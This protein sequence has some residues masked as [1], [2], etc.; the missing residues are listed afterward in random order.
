MSAFTLTSLAATLKLHF[1]RAIASECMSDSLKRSLFEWARC[2]KHN[3]SHLKMFHVGYQGADRWTVQHDKGDLLF[4]NYPYLAMH[5]I[6]G[7]MQAGG[8][9]IDTGAT[10]IDAGGCFGEFSLYASQCVGPSGRVLMLEPDEKNIEVAERNF[11]L[12]GSPANIQIVPAALWNKTGSIT[13]ATGQSQQSSLVGEAVKSSEAKLVE[14]PTL[15]VLDLIE[16]YHL[17]R[18]DFIKMDI[19]GAELEAMDPA[20][21][22]SPTMQPRYAIASYHLRDAKPTAGALEQM[23]RELGYHASS[24]NPRHLTTWAYRSTATP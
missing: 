16:R 14:V 23:F 24:G 6:E 1:R 19:E 18:L 12:N 17:D 10:V 7:Y 21:L 11:A 20:R 9:T 15:T 3:W 22:L 4:D 13:F 5:D 8:W 2:T